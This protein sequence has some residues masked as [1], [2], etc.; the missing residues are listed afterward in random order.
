[1]K[2]AIGRAGL[3]GIVTAVAV[4]AAAPASATDLRLTLRTPGSGG[5]IAVAVYANA[6]DLRASRN[7]VVSRIVPA[8]GAATTVTLTGLAPGRYAI[9]AYHDADSNG[10]LTLWPVG[11]PREAYG[12]SRDARGR[13]GPPAFDAAA[14]DLPAAGAHQAITLR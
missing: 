2:T 1:M 9:G 11:L 5:S 8:T 4:L 3:T 12:F 14:F 10:A 7:P 6:A 13:F